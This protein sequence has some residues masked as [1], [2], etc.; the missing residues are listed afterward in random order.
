MARNKSEQEQLEEEGYAEFGKLISPILD[1]FYA[2]LTANG[3]MDWF[4]LPK[5][6]ELTG[7]KEQV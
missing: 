5:P 1:M 4:R 3:G 6:E 7:G 2:G